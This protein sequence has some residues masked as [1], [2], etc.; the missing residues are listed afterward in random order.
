MKASRA[1]RILPPRVPPPPRVPCRTKFHPSMRPSVLSASTVAGRS[2]CAGFQFA[3]GASARL[4]HSHHASPPSQRGRGGRRT[5]E[6]GGHIELIVGPMFSGKSTE[7]L[8]RVRR[9]QCADEACVVVRYENDDR[10]DASSPESGETSGDGVIGDIKPVATHDRDFS[11]PDETVSASRLQDI[12]DEPAVARASVV[13][14]DEGQ[15][16]P[17]VVTACERWANAGKVVIVA[18]LDGTFQRRP[19]DTMQNLISVSEY[20]TKLQAVCMVCHRDAAFSRRLGDETQI[21]VIGG[22]DK[23]EAVC[24]KCYHSGE[25][26]I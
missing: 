22:A 14:I 12:W 6:F 3:M 11:V 10:Y 17:D 23:Y 9:Y 19:F 5:E 1:T 25:Q 8:R 20:V 2:G 13:A 24:R 4:L 7:L 21:E 18:A 15:F 26:R 16:F